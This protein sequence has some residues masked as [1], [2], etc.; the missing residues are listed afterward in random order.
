VNDY[1]VGHVMSGSHGHYVGGGGG[2]GESTSSYTCIGAPVGQGGGFGS[3]GGGGGKDG[4]L[5]NNQEEGLSWGRGYPAGAQHRLDPP[6]A[7]NR[8][9]D[10]F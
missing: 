9:Q 10:G 5:H 4:S 7:I 1:Y 2:G 3:G 8:F 6:S